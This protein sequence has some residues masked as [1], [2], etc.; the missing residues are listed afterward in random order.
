MLEGGA[1]RSGVQ[2]I[3]TKR[4]FPCSHRGG[5][6]L[7]M[8]QPGSVVRQG[9]MI[10]RIV[11]FTGLEVER[12]TAEQDV[13]VIGVLENPVVPSGKIVAV[14][15]LEWEDVDILIDRRY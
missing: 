13:V 2:K 9:E 3:I 4:S 10:A 11:D 8:C 6:A 7:P 12:M 5:L 15:G 14:C 1:A